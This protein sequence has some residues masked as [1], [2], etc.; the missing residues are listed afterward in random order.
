MKR[1]VRGQLAR[2]RVFSV[3]GRHGIANSRTLEQKISDSGPFDQRIDPHV[4]TVVRNTLVDDDHI[5]RRVVGNALWFYLT[6]ALKQ[7]VQSRLDEIG[8]RGGSGQARSTL[9][10]VEESSRLD[11]QD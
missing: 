2:K 8:R 5:R 11:D 1:G 7:I 6:N 4:L 10:I 9:A 3:L